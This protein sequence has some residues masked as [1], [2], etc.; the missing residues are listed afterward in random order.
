MSIVI[1]DNILAIWYS[2]L[3]E[4]ED[5]LMAISRHEGGIKFVYRVRHYN[6]DDIDPLDDKDD[7]TWAEFGTNDPDEQKAIGAARE[8]VKGLIGLAA[9]LG[10]VRLPHKIYELVRGDD[11]VEQFAKKLMAAP[12]AHTQKVTRQ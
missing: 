3:G 5:Y 10:R 7:K 11:S 1:D 6:S 9:G 4:T 12:F 8:M 2:T